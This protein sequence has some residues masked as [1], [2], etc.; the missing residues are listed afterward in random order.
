MEPRDE[1]IIFFS[2]LLNLIYCPIMPAEEK[3]LEK[4]AIESM[5]LSNKPQN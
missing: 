2:K 1:G 5:D 4:F 3:P